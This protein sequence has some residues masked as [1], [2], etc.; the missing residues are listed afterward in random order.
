[1]LDEGDAAPVEQDIL[2]DCYRAAAMLHI[3]PCTVRSWSRKG[4]LE[5][6]NPGEKG[7]ALYRK[8]DIMRLML[9]RF[10]DY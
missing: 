3:H 5:R 9:A 6:V 7:R 1:V 10:S 4:W 2:T 8:D